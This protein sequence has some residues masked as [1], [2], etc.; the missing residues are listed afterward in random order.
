M[1]ETSERRNDAPQDPPL[2]FVSFWNLGG[3]KAVIGVELLTCSL[4]A[5]VVSELEQDNHRQWHVSKGDAQG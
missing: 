5:A 1:A 3:T 4:C 2:G